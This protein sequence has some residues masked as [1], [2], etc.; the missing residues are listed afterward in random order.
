MTWL[1]GVGLYGHGMHEFILRECEVGTRVAYAEDDETCGFG[2][3]FDL[4]YETWA[5]AQSDYV[6]P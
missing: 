2:P 3:L 1:T 4:R 6:E 5:R